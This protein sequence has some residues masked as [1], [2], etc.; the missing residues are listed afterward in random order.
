M[1]VR[2]IHEVVVGFDLALDKWT[3]DPVGP[4]CS[5]GECLPK[6]LAV[7]GVMSSFNSQ[8]PAQYPSVSARMIELVMTVLAAHEAP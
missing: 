1:H 7:D 3:P 2:R 4:V 5:F 6:Q 8:T